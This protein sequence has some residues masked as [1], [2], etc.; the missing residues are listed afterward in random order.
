MKT[1]SDDVRLC[2]LAT[3]REMNSNSDSGAKVIGLVFE[4]EGAGCRGG[5]T[6]L[7]TVQ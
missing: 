6:T 1:L 3:S 4:I 7:L 2:S 5:A